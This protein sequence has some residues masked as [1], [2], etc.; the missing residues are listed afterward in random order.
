M[1]SSRQSPKRSALRLGV[2]LVELFDAIPRRRRSCLSCW[3]RDSICRSLCRRAVRGGG[4]RPSST[5]NFARWAWSCRSARPSRSRSRRGRPT[6]VAA[7]I[8]IDVDIT[9]RPTS[10]LGTVHAENQAT[11]FASRNSNPVGPYEPGL[12]EPSRLPVR[13]GRAACRI[14]ATHRHGQAACVKARCH[15]HQSRTRRR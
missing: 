4:R 14:D 13:C 12:R 8:G 15:C 6:F 2:D 7:I 1:I 3:T 10:A 11:V 9:P 5:Q